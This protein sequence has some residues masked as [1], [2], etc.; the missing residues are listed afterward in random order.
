MAIELS[1]VDFTTF[2]CILL[3]GF[4]ALVIGLYLNIFSRGLTDKEL[5]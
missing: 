3:L 1:N 5:Q 2:K 4:L